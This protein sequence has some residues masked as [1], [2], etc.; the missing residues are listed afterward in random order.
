MDLTFHLNRVE[1]IARLGQEP[2][3]RYTPSGQ[4]VVTFSVATDR[5]TKPDAEPIVDWHRAV[6]W[7]RLAEFVNQ[8]VTKGRLVYI[9]GRL[10]YRAWES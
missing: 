4:A 9:S 2:E 6:C 10:H 1:L 8:Y 5:P 7:D 3:F